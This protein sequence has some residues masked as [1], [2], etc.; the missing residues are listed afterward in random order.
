MGETL[1][2]IIKIKNMKE[3]IFVEGLPGSG[4]ATFCKNFAKENNIATYIEI[5]ILIN[6]RVKENDKI[7]LNEYLLSKIQKIFLLDFTILVK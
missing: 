4:E 3:I 5:D 2:C 1:V 6:C 7:P